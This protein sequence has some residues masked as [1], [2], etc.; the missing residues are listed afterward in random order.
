MSEQSRKILG[1]AEKH[2]AQQKGKKIE[3][4]RCNACSDRAIKCT[5]ALDAGRTEET[6][7]DPSGSIKNAVITFRQRLRNLQTIS[8]SLILTSSYLRSPSFLDRRYS[9]SLAALD[10]RI[11]FNIFSRRFDVIVLP[12][13]LPSLGWIS[14]VTRV[15][16]LAGD[17][18]GRFQTYI[19]CR[20][21][22]FK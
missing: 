2:V 7:R 22:S 21:P 9:P 5:Q 20:R 18:S 14:L 13:K 11:A 4:C 19:D 6:V 1:R 16:E 17:S 8:P 3:I 12:E 15:N 10:V